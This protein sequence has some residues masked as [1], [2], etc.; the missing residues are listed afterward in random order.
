[1]AT[2]IGTENRLVDTLKN[3]IQLDFDA[4]EAYR[5]AIKRIDH[6]EIKTRVGEFMSDHERHT[7]ELSELVREL[8]DTPPTSGDIKAMLTKGKVV[9]GNLIGDRGVLK[10]MKSNE[11]ETNTAY[12]QAL[13]RTDI[14]PVRVR[15]VLERNLEDERRHRAWIEQKLAQIG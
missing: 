8:G 6:A 15:E 11:D 3:L 10:A 12:E 7:R 5:A 13:A 9:I 4:I 14:S 2:T 1:M